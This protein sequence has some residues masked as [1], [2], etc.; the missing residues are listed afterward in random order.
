MLLQLLP[1]SDQVRRGWRAKWE[2]K[3]LSSSAKWDA[4]KTE[5]KKNEVRLSYLPRY[6]TVSHALPHIRR[7]CCLRWRT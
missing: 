3:P 5:A 4:V 2:V 1:V 6:G 7:L